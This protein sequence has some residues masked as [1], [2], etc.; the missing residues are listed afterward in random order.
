MKFSDS[1]E[2]PRRLA[3]YPTHQAHQAQTQ[4]SPRWSASVPV[5]SCFS[6]CVISHT[7]ACS[8]SYSVS[9]AGQIHLAFTWGNQS[10][11]VIISQGK[12]STGLLQVRLFFLLSGFCVLGGKSNLLWAPRPLRPHQHGGVGERQGTGK[13]AVLKVQGRQTKEGLSVLPSHFSVR[14]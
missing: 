6:Y 14:P 10:L 12:E 8:A 2:T 13:M 3:A 4:G 5:P 9:K 11:W 7:P 1:T